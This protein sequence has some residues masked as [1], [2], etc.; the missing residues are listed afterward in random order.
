MYT[1]GV[2]PVSCRWNGQMDSW[3]TGLAGWLNGRLNGWIGLLLLLY[4][5]AELLL[6]LLPRA[7]TSPILRYALLCYIYIRVPIG[8]DCHLYNKYLGLPNLRF[9]CYLVSCGCCFATK[10]AK[11][12]DKKKSVHRNRPMTM[13]FSYESWL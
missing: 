8:H 9:V 13:I 12:K 11:C 7:T 5:A 4:L 1:G 6:M 10:Q 3:L 2:S